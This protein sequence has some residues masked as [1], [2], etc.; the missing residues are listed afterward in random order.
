MM[1]L[2]LDSVGYGLVV[3]SSAILFLKI[4]LKIHTQ[5]KYQTYLFSSVLPWESNFEKRYV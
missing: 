1:N 3:D 2:T 4:S 5:K